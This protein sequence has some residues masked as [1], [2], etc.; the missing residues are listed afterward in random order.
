MTGWHSHVGEQLCLLSR[1]PI[2]E[3]D[4]LGWDDLAARQRRG[5]GTSQAAKYFIDMPQG[6]I[7]FA[8][9]HLETPRKGL[10]G[11][12]Q[13]KVGRLS[14]NTS[15]RAE[16]SRRTREW[17]GQDDAS[18]VVVGDFNTP[19]ESAIYRREWSKFQNA[20]SETGTGFGVTWRNGWIQVRIDHVLTG[21]AWRVRRAVVGPVMGRDHRPL[22]VDLDW[23]AGVSS[24]PSPVVAGAEGKSGTAS[25][26]VSAAPPSGWPNEPAGLTMLTD[27]PWNVKNAPGWQCF[28]PGVP[29]EQLA[30]VVSD[31]SA[32]SSPSSVLEFLYPKGHIAG[33]GG[34]F[35]WYDLNLNEIFIGTYFKYIEGWQQPGS[36]Y[37]KLFYVFQELNYNR[38]ATYMVVDGMPN[39][40]LELKINNEA[41]GGEWWLQNMTNV[42][43]TPGTWY[44]LELYMKKAS[45]SGAADGIVRWWVDGVLAANHTNARLRGEPFT[46]FPL[47]PLW[48]GIGGT[49]SR[50][51]WLRYDHTYIS[52]R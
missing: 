30:N 42:Q 47:H 22:I 4:V 12:L 23:V 15:L 13:L 33:T 9:L 39:G 50:D 7:G 11:A 17:L 44:R 6:A 43:L 1:H 8:N 20:F 26:T 18:L 35:C 37:S 5:G 14:E 40:K 49:K 48:G 46:Q 51:E 41:G 31:P 2:R 32:P 28:N 36:N 29:G 10:E 21:P 38:Q 27:N 19:V 16:E 45:V 25:V 34:E 3:A 24:V 52:G